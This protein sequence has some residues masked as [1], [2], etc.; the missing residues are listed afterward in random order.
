MNFTVNDAIFF[1]GLFCGFAACVIIILAAALINWR[2][3]HANFVVTG[4]D[5]EG[6][7]TVQCLECN[8]STVVPNEVPMFKYCPH[9]GREVE[10]I[11]DKEQRTD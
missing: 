5:T 9:C 1:C 4:E 2:H 6:N 10:K 3:D 11:I 8:T 7:L